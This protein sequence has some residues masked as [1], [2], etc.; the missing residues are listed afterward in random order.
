MGHKSLSLIF[1]NT[2]ASIELWMAK[3]ATWDLG[4]GTCPCNVPKHG[5]IFVLYYMARMG[6]Q[7]QIL[8]MAQTW[9]Q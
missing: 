9:M 7:W 4:H 6:A 1:W 2:F 3:Q 5:K 8:Q